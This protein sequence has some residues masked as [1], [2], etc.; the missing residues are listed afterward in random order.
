MMKKITL[1]GL[2]L[3]LGAGFIAQ[4]DNNMVLNPSFEGANKLKKLGQIKYAENWM[5]ATGVKADLY[6]T[7]KS[8]PC[9]APVNANGKEYPLTEKRMLEL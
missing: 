8:L 6:S 5:S 2:A 3:F 9:S 1:F 7:D 4:D